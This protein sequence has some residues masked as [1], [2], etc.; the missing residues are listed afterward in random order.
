MTDWRAG[1]ENEGNGDMGWEE[2]PTVNTLVASVRASRFNLSPTRGAAIVLGI[3]VALQSR[4]AWAQILRVAAYNIDAD[5]TDFGPDAGPG[6]IP[7]LQAM[8]N[9]HLAGH[10]QALDALAFEARATSPATT[11]LAFIQRT[12]TF[13]GP[14]R[15]TLENEANDRF[16]GHKR[17][18]APGVV[19]VNGG[20]VLCD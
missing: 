13:A 15:P 19:A 10:T 2:K 12:V 8:G 16:P 18:L 6:L 5:T 11:I 1:I 9:A 3:V 20:N 14:G 7:V 4:I 17:R